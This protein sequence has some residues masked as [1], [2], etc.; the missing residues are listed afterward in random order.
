MYGLGCCVRVSSSILRTIGP[1]F[2]RVCKLLLLSARRGDQRAI[3]NVIGLLLDYLD[4]S[5]R[6]GRHRGS[7]R[8][9]EGD[10]LI[11]GHGASNS[12]H[13]AVQ[14]VRVGHDPPPRRRNY[15]PVGIALLQLTQHSGQV[16]S[17][18]RQVDLRIGRRIEEFC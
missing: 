2:E 18:V 15:F 3:C 12:S 10:D 17:T 11:G 16:R 14:T 6:F 7:Q 9:D 13:I 1:T 8:E 4:K 5:Q